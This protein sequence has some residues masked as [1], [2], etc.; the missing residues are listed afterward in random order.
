MDTFPGADGKRHPYPPPYPEPT[1]NPRTVPPSPPATQLTT[2][3]R[4]V[5]PFLNITRLTAE[6]APSAPMSQVDWI[7]VPSD[8][9]R[10]YPS[11]VSSIRVTVPVTNSASH[12][13]LISASIDGRSTITP[14]A[15]MSTPLPSGRAM[16]IDSAFA[17][18]ND[19]FHPRR[20]NIPSLTASPQTLWYLGKAVPE[21]LSITIVLNPDPDRCI[22]ADIPEGPEPT[23][24]T[25][26][27]KQ[28]A[29][30]ATIPPS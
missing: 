12:S 3:M 8:R 17:D 10:A 29:S 13:D 15:G 11:P 30:S 23:T 4:S 19:G 25:S 20:S 14:E 16:R 26:Q 27:L 5:N 1:E 6:W 22:A 2:W 28:G 7:L 18:M 9:V 21:S 24:A